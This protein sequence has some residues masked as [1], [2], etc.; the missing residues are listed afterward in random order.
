MNRN[1]AVFQLTPSVQKISAVN[2]PREFPKQ[3]KTKI[4][5]EYLQLV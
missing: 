5:L 4:L 1:N 2:G 3:N